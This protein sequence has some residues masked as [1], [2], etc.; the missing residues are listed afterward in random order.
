VRL[1]A[2]GVTVTNEP[3]GPIV[4][5]LL[6]RAIGMVN[7]VDA[8]DKIGGNAGDVPCCIGYGDELEI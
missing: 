8:P 4:T 6:F 3:I 7:G 2:I 5:K 1:Y